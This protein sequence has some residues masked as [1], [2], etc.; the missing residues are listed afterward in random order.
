M[1]GLG[2]K[3]GEIDMSH[4]SGSHCLRKLLDVIKKMENGGDIFKPDKNVADYHEKKF[5]VFLEMLKDQNKYKKMM[6]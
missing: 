2:F 3:I 1:F 5:Q 6:D 4:E